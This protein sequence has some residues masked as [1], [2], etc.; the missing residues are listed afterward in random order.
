MDNQSTPLPPP[1]HPGRSSRDA[2]SA[3]V[4]AGD[5]G[6]TIAATLTSIL[7][8]TMPPARVV[9]VVAG[10]RDDTFAV[11]RTF[12]GRHAHALADAGHAATT[13]TVIDR[14][15]RE[16]SLRSAYGFALRLVDDAGRVLLVAP[17]AELK[18]DVLQLLAAALERDPGAR[19]VSASL[20]P[21]PSGSH[22]PLAGALQVLQRH[23]AM[24]AVETGIDL[25]LTG[26]VPLAPATLL[27]LPAADAPSSSAASSEG[28]LTDLLAGDDRSA[29]V[30][31]ARAR[32]DTAVTWGMMRER[33]DR[34][35]AHVARLARGGSPADVGDRRRARL[36]SLRIGIGPVLR[37]VAY[38]LVALYLAAA[39]M[40]GMLEPAWWWAVPVVVRLP[41]H[42][43]TLRR[44][45]ERTAA[46]V[47]FGATFLPLE[48]AEAAYGVSRIRDGLHRMAHR[49]RRRG[50][51]AAETVPPFSRVDAVAAAAVAL[52]VVGVL[53]VAEVGGP[54]AAG[55]ITMVGW[56]ACVVTAADLVMALLRLLV[57]HGGPFARPSAAGGS[58]A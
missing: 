54:A 48:A 17:D 3:V 6:S 44:I 2:V 22:G 32:V 45:R 18:P 55:L 11:A 31:G 23:W 36:A 10:S 51:A 41:L 38:A 29:L 25:G 34:W 28:I 42:I 1:E 37:F 8:Q 39:G 19:S 43:R 7:G 16:G 5:A 26:P 27:R 56:A 9:V 15:P 35:G 47:L 52:V 20:D 46:D 57:A 50:P 24:G 30:P 13:V 21:R 33:R 53:A 14:G 12:N 49:G 40:Q 4:V 58:E